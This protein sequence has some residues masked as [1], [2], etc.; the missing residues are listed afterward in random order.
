[1]AAKKA[2]GALTALQVVFGGVA[3]VAAIGLGMMGSGY[4]Q[5]WFNYW[6][7]G[8]EYIQA[9]EEYLDID[10]DKLKKDYKH[11]K[12]WIQ[13]ED[14]DISYP[15]MQSKDNDY[16]LHRDPKGEPSANGSI[17]IDHKVDSLINSP[18]V[19]IYGHNMN[20]GSMF[21][22]L[23]KY[24]KKKFYEEGTHEVRIYTKNGVRIYEIFSVFIANPRD[25]IVYKI[26]NDW[27]DQPEIL[28]Y[29]K[30]ERKYKTDVDVS[31]NDQILT[32]STCENHVT[33]LTI[34]ARYDRFVEL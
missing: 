19:V 17:F 9:G 1:M 10:F 2:K 11:V 5:S 13:I 27:S 8:N 14:L 18:H 20:D 7:M 28:K 15:V 6:M 3:V 31:N 23:K 32:L 34:H 29:F 33:R 30:S 26:T 16:F 22:K 4:I 24:L 12:G 21:G 25:K